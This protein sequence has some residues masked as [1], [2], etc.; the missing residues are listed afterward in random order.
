MLEEVTFKIIV[1]KSAKFPRV[2]FVIDRW[3]HNWWSV[4]CLHITFLCFFF[5]FFFIFR[6]FKT[7]LFFF[8]FFYL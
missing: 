2:A 7:F 6:V 1:E 4:Y 3:Y 5:F 8:E